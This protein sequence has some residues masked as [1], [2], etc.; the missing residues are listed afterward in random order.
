MRKKLFISA[1]KSP[2]I[3]NER[4]WLVIRATQLKLLRGC[5]IGLSKDVPIDLPPIDLHVDLPKMLAE[6]IAFIT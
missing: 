2:R 3:E 4:I 6:S 1:E 5:A